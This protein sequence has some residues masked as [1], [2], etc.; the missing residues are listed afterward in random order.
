M[1]KIGRQ[2]TRPNTL[3]SAA[4]VRW[5]TLAE[6]VYCMQLY[7]YKYRHI[8]WFY[9][10]GSEDSLQTLFGLT[11]VSSAGGVY[12]GFVRL[13]LILM[14]SVISSLY[15]QRERRPSRVCGG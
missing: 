15:F 2:K 7:C 8:F 11:T 4:S 12:F 1:V 13:G 3:V 5:R 10:V 14:Q 6:K 9:S